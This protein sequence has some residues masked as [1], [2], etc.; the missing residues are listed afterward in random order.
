MN[1]DT[2]TRRSRAKQVGRLMQCYRL[3]RAG[4]GRGGRLSQTGL[5]ALMGEIKEEYRDYSHSTVARWESGEILPKRGRLEVFGAALGLP[6]AEIDGLVALAGLGDN[7]L[8][9]ADNDMGVGDI[10]GDFRPVLSTGRSPSEELVRQGRSHGN[11]IGRFL[12]A[13]LLLPG[14]GIA[15]AGFFLGA[16]GFNA[17]WMLTAYIVA[18]IGAMLSHY[19]LPLRRSRGLRDFLF[20][21][22]FVLL[23][24]PMLQAP[25]MKMDHFGFYA[26][27]GL[28]GTPIPYVLALLVNLALAFIA[29]LMYDYLTRWQDSQGSANPYRRAAWV[30]VP[31]LAFVYVSMLFISCAGTWLYL[32]EALPVL[33]GVLMA[34]L[35]LRDES[36]QIS[37]WTKRFLLQCTFAITIV[38]TMMSLA[39]MVVVYLEP[40]LQM[41]A[42][43]TLLRSW[44]VDFNELGYSQE[45]FIDRSRISTV[46]SSLAA[47]IYMVA[48]VAG[49][50]V[51]TI[52]KKDPKDSAAAASALAPEAVSPASHKR[53]TK[54]TRIDSRYRPG[55][56]T[57]SRVVKPIQGIAAYTPG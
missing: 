27:D 3:D 34:I 35:V 20:I 55:W 18:I 7:D 17:D 15:G 38:L 51:V 5:L 4:R 6:R 2:E 24:T 22:V 37:Q 14:L 31:P 49:S 57:G 56:L 25:L 53:Q 21:S 39:G 32:L 1:L 46:W 26:I 8:G 40:S 52:V 33:G 30:T 54:R 41:V 29:A 16:V 19:F 48:I 10:T 11:D 45:E 42:D 23:S 28:G 9:H 43:H 36:I 13:K 50:L 44:E 47:I 12:L